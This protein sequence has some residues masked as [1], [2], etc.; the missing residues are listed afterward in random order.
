M[1]SFLSVDLNQALVVQNL[2]DCI[3]RCY[4]WT[5]ESEECSVKAEQRD[6]LCSKIRIHSSRFTD[7]NEKVANDKLASFNKQRT[8]CCRNSL[9]CWFK[10]NVFLSAI[11]SFCGF[12]RVW[13][14]HPIHLICSGR[15]DRPDIK[16]FA[17]GKMLGTPDSRRTIL[18]GAVLTPLAKLE[19]TF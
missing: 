3:Q 10:S 6:S 12:R 2:S 8:N 9:S 1:W 15:M 13:R 14:P 18:P 5:G 16:I 7:G 11:P 4:Y 17:V 19:A